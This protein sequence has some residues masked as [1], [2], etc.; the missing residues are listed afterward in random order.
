M[1]AEVFSVRLTNWKS[2]F[3]LDSRKSRPNNFLLLKAHL[4]MFTD[5]FLKVALNNKKMSV[6]LR[7]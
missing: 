2:S 4:G 1:Q 6:L 7:N 3:K 5:D